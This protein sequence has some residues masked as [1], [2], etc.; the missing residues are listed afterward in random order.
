V[1]VRTMMIL[2]R[3]VLLVSLPGC[4]S[5]SSASSGSSQA[6]VSPAFECVGVPVLVGDDW[7]PVA[8]RGF[9]FCVPLSWSEPDPGWRGQPAEDVVMGPGV[10]LAWGRGELKPILVPI[11]IDPIRRSEQRPPP[12]VPPYRSDRILEEIGGHWAEIQE[13]QRGAETRWRA[14]WPITGVW[15]QAV[16]PEDAATEDLIRAIFRTVRINAAPHAL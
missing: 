2:R 8:A 7:R 5:G 4:A 16:S 6:V 14:A 3:M 15:L 13:E 11:R 10:I 9:T 12:A 1:R